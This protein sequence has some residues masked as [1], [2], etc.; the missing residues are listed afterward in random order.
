M[1]ANELELVV[2]LVASVWRLNK[3]QNVT[4]KWYKGNDPFKTKRII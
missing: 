2:R 4:F 3:G 1:T